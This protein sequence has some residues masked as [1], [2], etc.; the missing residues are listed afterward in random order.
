ML[1]PKTCWHETMTSFAHGFCGAG[2][3]AGN[4]GGGWPVFAPDVWS[5]THMSGS[6]CWLLI[7]PLHVA[8]ASSQHGGWVPRANI[9]TEKEPSGSWKSH[10][11]T[12]FCLLEMS[13]KG[14][15]IFQGRRN[16]APPL[17]REGSKNLWTCFKAIIITKWNSS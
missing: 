6:W 4:S 14:Q 3:G 5:L 1:L 12:S 9:P 13:H 17:L 2:I 11:L 8:W 16:Q 7:G 15:L 10:S